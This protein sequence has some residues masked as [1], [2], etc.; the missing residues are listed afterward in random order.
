MDQRCH[1]PISL[2]PWTSLR[3]Q[4]KRGLN[5]APRSHHTL[6]PSC[7]L[8]KPAAAARKTWEQAWAPEPTIRHHPRCREVLETSWVITGGKEYSWQASPDTGRNPEKVIKDGEDPPLTQIC[9]WMK[10]PRFGGPGFLGFTA[11]LSLQEIH[12]NWLILEGRSFLS[13][14]LSHYSQPGYIISNII[15]KLST[16]KKLSLTINSCHLLSNYTMY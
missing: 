5:L 2:H 1:L 9:Q 11:T 8:T 7:M 14:C 13:I 4:W 10:K 16:H 6:S 3:C 15:Y 12:I